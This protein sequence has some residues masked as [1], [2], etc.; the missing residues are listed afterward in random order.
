MTDLW[1]SRGAPFANNAPRICTRFWVYE[2]HWCGLSFSGYISDLMRNFRFSSPD[3]KNLKNVANMLLNYYLKYTQQINTFHSA[4]LL[5]FFLF[6]VIMQWFRNLL[7][8]YTSLGVYES[9]IIPCRVIKE[10]KRPIIIWF[11]P[12][13]CGLR[14]GC[15]LSFTGGDLT[16]ECIH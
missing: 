14:G 8:E 16:E 10:N 12:I 2:I 3:R 9:R 1:R 6:S 4:L 11:N 7:W 13:I 15:L 5:N